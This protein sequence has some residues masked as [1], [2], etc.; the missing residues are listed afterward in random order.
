M[1]YSQIIWAMFYGSIFF[2]ESH[3]LVTAL[4]TGVIIASGVYIVLR[5]DKPSV[6]LNRPVLETRSRLDF[7]LLPRISFLARLLNARRAGGED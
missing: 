1:Q 6:S 4:G 7:G 2:H 5:E 3:D